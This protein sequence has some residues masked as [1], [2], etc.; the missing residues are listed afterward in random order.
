MKRFLVKCLLLALIVGGI[1]HLGGL[2]YQRTTAYENLERNDNTEGFSRMPEQIDLAVLGPSHG[3]EDFL[4]FPEGRTAFNF[5][6]SS[7]TAQYDWMMLRQYGDRLADGAVVVMT[8]SYLS[9]FWN[10][11]PEQFQAKQER[12]YRV[13]DPWN[14]VD[15]DLA[16]W[17]LQRFSP[18]LVNAPA[19][20]AAAFLDPEPL[21]P[22]LE[23]KMHTASLE[24]EKIP[25]EQERIRRNHLSSI[26]RSFPEVNA[27]MWEAYHEMLELCR[28]K[29]WNAVLV[30]PPYSEAYNQCFSEEFFSVFWERMETLSETYGVPL[31]DYSHDARFTGRIDLFADLDHLNFTGAEAFDAVVWEDLADLGLM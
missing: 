31:L 15:V 20:I 27:T 30:V 26:Q 25:E 5:A 9:P 13:L 19:E 16:H 3:M 8:V 1:L 2:A 28:D 4:V 11:T 18:L 10:D 17:V 6:L 12:Y 14:I 7:Q 21:N 29:G 22:T 23:E 24:E